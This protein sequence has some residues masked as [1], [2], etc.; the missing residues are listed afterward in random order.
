MP[1]SIS[2]FEAAHEAV[3]ASQ[4]WAT[5]QDSFTSCKRVLIFGNGG[6]LAIADHG[7]IDISRLTDKSASAPG[8]GILASSIINDGGHAL[9]LKNWVDISLRGLSPQS[10]SHCLVIGISSSGAA[11]NVF[12]ALEHASI[13]GSKAGLISSLPPRWPS[14]FSPVVLGLN[15]YHTAEVL[16]LMLIYQLIE[17]SGFSCPSISDS[18]NNQKI[19][20]YSIRRC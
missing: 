8:S 9:W 7:A 17:G 20:D 16:T 12:D 1:L 13:L 4:E 3:L 2:G 10:I 6:N 15:N 11:K 5:L 14:S 18:L 19:F